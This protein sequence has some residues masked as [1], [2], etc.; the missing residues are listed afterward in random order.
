MEITP[1]FY[2]NRGLSRIDSGAGGGY[3]VPIVSFDDVTHLD[4]HTIAIKIDVKGYELEVLAGAKLFFGRNRGYA[5]I[6][7]LD[8]R[9]AANIIERMAAFGWRLVGRHGINLR[10]ERQRFVV[11]FMT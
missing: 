9:I 6:E 8:N 1:A 5:Q 7:A 4:G 10:F 2:E 11:A 3:N